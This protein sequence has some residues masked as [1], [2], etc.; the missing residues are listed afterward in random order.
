MDRWKCVVIDVGVI[1][2]ASASHSESFVCVFYDMFWSRAE[3]HSAI[4]QDA[5]RILTFFLFVTVFC[6][7]SYILTLNVPTPINN[8]N[9]T[10][11]TRDWN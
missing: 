2:D 11:W 4:P 5:T 9:V 6:S 10:H 7:L 3:D 1:L 8:E